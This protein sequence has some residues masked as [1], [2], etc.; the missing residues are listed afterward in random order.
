MTTATNHL[1]NRTLTSSAEASVTD[2]L[3]EYFEATKTGWRRV[4]KNSP[5]AVCG[6]PDWCGLTGNDSFAVCMR[7]SS[8]SI[9]ETK[10]GG[11]IHPLNYGADRV[12]QGTPHGTRT[13][14]T[15][16]V[17]KTCSP[18]ST[19]REESDELWQMRK[20]IV[21]RLL[22][23]MSP[24]T[25]APAELIYAPDGLAARGLRDRAK[26]YGMLP[27]AVAERTELARELIKEVGRR[28]PALVQYAPM[29]RNPLA[30]VPGFWTAEDG[31][32]SLWQREDHPGPILIVPYRDERGAVRG[33][34]L[35]SPSASRQGWRYQW[36]SSATYEKQGASP[37]TP[38][39]F[40]DGPR[41]TNQAAMPVMITEG[42]LKADSC[43]RAL[44]K[45]VII[46]TSGVGC[47]HEA[48]IEASST[49][50]RRTE[51][52]TIA[53]D[54]DH[55]TNKSVCQQIARLAAGLRKE[56]CLTR[57]LLWPVTIKG[58]DD[59]LLAQARGYHF[60]F[61]SL[62]SHE[63]LEHLPEEVFS[64]ARKS[65]DILWDANR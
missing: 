32:P 43:G 2:F 60:E 63:W 39:H 37:G 24:A 46:A 55:R 45:P 29:P 28:H 42:A 26:R 61:Q 53:F 18:N 31:T 10:H 9:G 58:I 57:I 51:R 12:V 38:V 40:A 23:E 65:F 50:A 33:C 14:R 16:T 5:C 64:Y 3:K 25:L 34:Q 21:Y 52:V 15:K 35:R 22:I 4:S 7:E 54:G 20:N 59:A 17:P 44:R 6:K 62:E 1:P 30:G 19:L 13:K 56:N 49:I 47:A 8:G 27:G 41:R 11:F 48:L 36:L